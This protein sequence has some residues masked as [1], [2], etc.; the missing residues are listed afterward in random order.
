MAAVALLGQAR[1]WLRM[2]RPAESKALLCDLIRRS[3]LPELRTQ[4]F[5][6]DARYL[7]ALTAALEL[8]PNEPPGPFN[9]HCVTPLTSDWSLDR[10]LDW[11]ENGERGRVSAP[12]T[13]TPS[14][15]ARGADATPL[16]EEVVEVQQGEIALVR[17][18][19]HQISLTALLDRLAERAALR[20]E[21]SARARQQVEERSVVVALERTSLPDVLRVLT[22]P[23]GLVWSIQG[24]KLS[25]ASEE[26]TSAERL[27]ALRGHN[28]RRTLRDVVRTYPHHPLTPVAF[29][30]L[31]DL[32][33]LMGHADEALSWYTRLVREWPRSQLVIE[34]QYNLGLVRCRQGD[35]PGAR[36][37]FYR[38]IDRAPAHELAPL[39]YWRVGRIYLDEGDAEQALSPLRRALRSGPGT[40]AQAAAVLTIAAAHLLTDNPAP[41]TPSCWS[42]A[43]S[44]IRIASAPRPSSSIR[45]RAFAPPPIAV[46]VS[47]RPA[48][49]WPLCSWR[50]AIRFWDLAVLC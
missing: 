23:L 11:A 36:Q 47:A 50:T 43:S 9:D 22:E 2:R 37:A 15:N 46:S 49:C 18:F 26:E 3:A 40:A 13:N 34:G 41:P 39:A 19:A 33:S 14:T 38:V 32:E 44:S 5:L 30:E 31:G 45:W 28:A 29:L 21:W 8:L 10:A 4:P 24:G 35:R 1:V 25:F 16:A 27:Q 48:I 20:I 12:S 17:L 6:A 7:L 42:I